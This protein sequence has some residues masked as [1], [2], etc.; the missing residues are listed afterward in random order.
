MRNKKGI[1]SIYWIITAIIAILILVIMI[2]VLNTGV[3]GGIN[4]LINLRDSTINPIDQEV[5]KCENLCMQAEV[6]IF[7]NVEQWRAS[8]YCRRTA[9]LDLNGDG[10]ISEEDGETGLRCWDQNGAYV[11]CEITLEDGTQLDQCNCSSTAC[12]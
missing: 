7:K 4:K 6:R 9:N 10:K 3:G 1:L 12:N 5:N 11:T 2:Y 8:S